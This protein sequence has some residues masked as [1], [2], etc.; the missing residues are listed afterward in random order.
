MSTHSIFAQK[1]IKMIASIIGGLSTVALSVMISR[2]IIFTELNHP[3][4][5]RSQQQVKT[6][7][8]QI[9]ADILQKLQSQ[10]SN[11]KNKNLLSAERKASSLS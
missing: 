8:Q 4:D 2:G 5:T 11:P 10:T 1:N 6:F 9:E 3:L 7:K